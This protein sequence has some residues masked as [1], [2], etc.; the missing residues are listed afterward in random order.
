MILS[1]LIVLYVG[2]RPTTSFLDSFLWGNG[3]ST[4]NKECLNDF[5]KHAP[6]MLK[7]VEKRDEQESFWK[8][9]SYLG[10]DSWWLFIIAKM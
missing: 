9:V 2:A 1:Y 4:C 8:L 7:L 3:K 10:F 6:P 5:F